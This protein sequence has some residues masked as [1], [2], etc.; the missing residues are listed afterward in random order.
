MKRLFLT[1]LLAVGIAGLGFSFQAGTGISV[2][3]PE[4]LYLHGKGSITIENNLQTS[5]SLSKFLSIPIGLTYDKIDGYTP[6]GTTALDAVTTPWFFGD[7][8]MGYVMAQV[9]LPVSIF[10]VNL[11]GGGALNWNATFTPIG[12]AIESYLTP[13]GSAGVAFPNPTYSAPWGYGW[14]AGASMGVTLKKLSISISA[15]YRDISS[16]L[17]LSGTYYAVNSAGTGASAAQY[18]TPTGA[19]AV[20]RGISVGASGDFKF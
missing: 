5:L 18:S 8:V 16:P 20:M 10:F 4:S 9:H 3:I 13:S 19:V 12:Q 11:Y 1:A 2:Y 15:L 14:V 7:S 17:K 6:G